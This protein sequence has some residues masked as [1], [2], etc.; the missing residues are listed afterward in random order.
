VKGLPQNVRVLAVLILNTT[1]E[2]AISIALIVSA[3]SRSNR[4]AGL[5]VCG[6]LG[7]N[8][9]RILS[10]LGGTM[11]VALEDLSIVFQQKCAPRQPR[12]GE[13][14]HLS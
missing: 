9:S 11:P 8:V 4:A 13:R 12:R 1:A 6:L 2:S 5:C 3:V 14:S 10:G 7:T